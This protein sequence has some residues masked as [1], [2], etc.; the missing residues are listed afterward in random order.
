MKH[1]HN[2]QV[3]VNLDFYKEDVEDIIDKITESII[4][5]VVV[6]TAAHILRK[7]VT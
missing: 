1:E 7:W 3:D 4:T 5:I 6:A 2:A